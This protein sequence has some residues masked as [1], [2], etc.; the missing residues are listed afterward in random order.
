MGVGHDVETGRRLYGAGF[1][2]SSF[3]LF[4]NAL[5]NDEKLLKAAR[6]EGYRIEFMPH[7]NIMPML[8]KFQKAEGVEFCHADTRYREIFARSSLIVTDYSSIAFDFAY[9]R[10]PVIYAQFD[11]QE[12]FQGHTYSEGYFDYQEMGLGEVEENLLYTVDRIL[13][14]MYND[15][16]MREKYRCRVDKFFA[17]RDKENSERVYDCIMNERI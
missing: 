16:R 11:R 10:K 2:E 15:C 4:Y 3:Y 12:F 7:P 17:F 14:Y 13:E 6:E 8:D 5:L 9:L 1:E